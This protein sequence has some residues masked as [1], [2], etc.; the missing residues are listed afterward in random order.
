MATDNTQVQ[1][2]D[3]TATTIAQ[4]FNPEVVQLAENTAPAGG[5]GN[6]AAPQGPVIPGAPNG[7]VTVNVPAGQTVV[8]VQVA[9]GETIDLPFDGALA[10]K[11]GAQGNLAIK[12]GD[13]TIILLGYGAANQQTGVTLHDH[14]GHAIDVA[15]VVAQTDPN[16]DIQ[17]AA[18]PAAGPAG[19]GGHLFFGFTPN[20]GLGGLGELGVINPTELQYKLIQPDEQI[21]LVQ[22]QDTSPQLISITQGNAVNE[23]DFHHTYRG[24]GEPSVQAAYIDPNQDSSASPGLLDQINADSHFQNVYWG[25]TFDIND[26]GSGSG[27]DPFDTNDHEDGSQTPG[28]S[29]NAGGIDQD[30]E[31]L[32]STAKVTVN[33][34][35]DLPGEIT[36]DS[37]GQIPIIT[38]LQNQI[39]TSQGHELLYALLPATATHGESIVAYYET[40]PQG[41]TSQ[42]VVFSL[43][44]QQPLG[45][46][47]TS[48]FDVTFTIFGTLDNPFGA[49][50][51]ADNAGGIGNGV[52]N[53]DAVFFMRDSNGSVVESP[54]G[55]LVFHDYDDKPELGRFEYGQLEGVDIPNA[56]DPA[57]LTIGIDEH[58]GA[59]GEY[60]HTGT[61][62]DADL[63][64]LD[65]GGHLHQVTPQA[66]DDVPD[67]FFGNNASEIAHNLYG[68]PGWELHDAFAGTT[69]PASFALSLIDNSFF[70]SG[71]HNNPGAGLNVFTGAAETYL[72]VSFGADG[73]AIGNQTFDGKPGKAGAALFDGAPADLARGFELYMQNGDTHP[74][75]PD[76]TAANKPTDQQLT[77]LT[78]SYFDGEKV[79][80]LAVTAYQLDA[81]TIIGISAQPD[82]VGVVTER[83]A[84]QE[85]PGY[86]GGG[87]PVFALH[88]DPGSGLLT[89]VQYHQVDNLDI[90]HNPTDITHLLT[91]HD[92]QLV[93]FRATD[94]DGDHI[95]APLEITFT[96]T[97][98]EIVGVVYNNEDQSQDSGKLD[99]DFL[100]N[101]PSPNHDEDTSNAAPNGDGP[102]G[103]SV[104][105]HIDVTTGVDLPV[106]FSF[107]IA[108]LTKD[109][110][111]VAATDKDGNPLVAAGGYPI[112]LALSKSGNDWVVTGK[113][114]DAQGSHDA[115]TLNLDSQTG[116]FNFLLIQAL[117]HPDHGAGRFEDNLNL[118]FGV[119]VTDTDK[120]SSTA[121]L[122]FVVND[123]APMMIE[124]PVIT[125]TQTYGAEQQVAE[126]AAVAVETPCLQE[127]IFR[128]IV[129]AD[130]VPAGVTIS[131]TDDKGAAGTVNLLAGKGIGV[132]SDTDGG[133]GGRFDEINFDQHGGVS[134]NGGSEGLTFHFDHL[135]SSG[136]V[137]LAKFFSG[138]GGVGDERGHWSALLNGVEVGHGDFEANSKTGQFGFA[139]PVIAG[140]FDTLVFTALTGS[141]VTG[142]KGDQSDYLVQRL[143]LVA[144]P[145][146][147]QSGEFAFRFGADNGN[148]PKDGHA[149]DPTNT[150]GGE[151]FVISTAALAAKHLTSGG[152]ELQY[153]TTYVEDP[154]T[155]HT[156]V[157]ITG[158][159]GDPA[160]GHV[161]FVLDVDPTAGEGSG[162]EHGVHYT[163]TDY[164]P[165]DNNVIGM[166]N[167]PFDVTITDRDGDAIQTQI[168]VCIDDSKPGIDGDPVEADVYEKGLTHGSTPGDGSTVTS[169]FF[170]FFYNGDGPGHITNV[171]FQGF[172]G[173]PL[174]AASDAV[175]DGLGHLVIN[176]ALFNLA[177]DEITGAYTFTLKTKLDHLGASDLIQD[178][179]FDL[180]VQDGDGS[181][182]HQVNALIIHDHDDV[183]TAHD[184]QNS[185]FGSVD[186]LHAAGNVVTGGGE[187]VGGSDTPGADGAHVDS[188]TGVGPAVAVAAGAGGSII[189]G[190]YGDL[191]LHQD[192][193]YT[194]AQ[195]SPAPDNVQNEAFTYVLKDGDGDVSPATLSIAVSHAPQIELTTG[196]EPQQ[197]IAKTVNLSL[198]SNP[199]GNYSVGDYLLNTSIE[200]HAIDPALVNG[201]NPAN[202][203]M[204]FG[205][206][207]TVTFEREG[208]AYHSLVGVY[209]FDSLGNIIPGSVKFLWL[210]ATQVNEDVLHSALVNDPLGNAQPLNVDI[211]NF[212]AG[213]NLGFFLM[214]NGANDASVVAALKT[215]TGG[216]GHGYATDMAA[217]N[218]LTSIAVDGSGHG[219]VVVNGTQLPGDV[220]FTNKDLNTVGD[221]AEHALSGVSTPPDG[222]LYIGFEDKK[223]TKA[224][225][226]YND[227]V[228]GVNLGAQNL[229]QFTPAVFSP[230][231]N[232]GD[233]DNDIKQIDLVTTGFLVGD[234]LLNLASANG[235]IVDVTHTTNDYTVHITESVPNSHDATQWQNFVNSIGF[236]SNSQ[237]DGERD[238]TYTVTDV[239][240]N[241]AHTTAKIDVVTQ[242]VESLSVTALE[243]HGATPGADVTWGAGDDILHLDKNFTATDGKLDMGGGKNTVLLDANGENFTHDDAQHLLNV[244]HIDM[245][246]HNGPNGNATILSY[247]DVIGMTGGDHVL[248]IDGDAGIDK[249]NLT[250][251]G[252]ATGTWAQA[253]DVTIGGHTYN[254]YDWHGS[255][256]NTPADVLASVLVEHNLVQSVTD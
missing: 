114:S 136:T 250:G 166:S 189:H 150:H 199:D 230:N 40:G 123:D 244:Q 202:L 152:V 162:G 42:F 31:P 128:I 208:A 24:E 38:A 181:E 167:L 25:S 46:T 255:G 160:G 134:G 239:S 48:T 50:D 177:V 115:F 51:P 66:T 232:L 8:R 102:G 122:S 241:T 20:G 175:S 254:Q 70:N 80:H 17:T 131:A 184:D 137:E 228:F 129:T 216:G 193:S 65:P 197:V 251:N 212:P 37:N 125:H 195:H 90:N 68:Y 91:N 56:F 213:T 83:L 97:V 192:G 207:V 2:G 12:S 23:D 64:T 6:A 206:D 121:T 222:N 130:N 57:N 218:A 4:E 209:N 113:Y 235:F 243:H 11:F 22:Q 108:G 77:N 100:Y 231:L 29:D 183:P 94:F 170:N 39:L 96:D 78:I 141:A 245:T 221:G 234:S 13:Q 72:Q 155:H 118:D 229:Q 110:D 111:Q 233:Q 32:S 95:D 43:E 165:L 52:F 62:Y 203:H 214:V 149:G 174:I 21:L 159:K 163:F 60:N 146:N 55:A 225:K 63:N 82:Q 36:F 7:Q 179:K 120:D 99:E 217:L 178:L 54:S 200:G 154:A 67:S 45:T 132:V 33:F 71:D 194:Y 140:G 44:I 93:H 143:D 253:A 81:N 41:E 35:N 248:Q 171:H 198:P 252:G 85:L 58:P 92:S 14:K 157:V 186:H 190:L 112:T 249:V 98:P 187:P 164:L 75:T 191:T 226:D 196:D 76:G 49:L 19:Q 16:L 215:A 73:E 15:T 185:V 188:A 126:V 59:Q 105:G 79:E 107:H 172:A 116:D 151:G 89:L 246:G 173:T 133:A 138:E 84:A 142:A 104:S 117:Q 27:N 247:Q 153:A 144:Q 26:N 145:I 227:I 47:S 88:L 256:G 86:D 147:V 18:G 237:I 224:D 69:Q 211:G 148:L 1:Q 238:I 87:I 180:K 5:A 61:S 168:A 28:H 30:R 74:G 106:S 119:Q 127:N 109:G 210:D 242:H 124:Q 176:N 158:Y 240:H 3:D 101:L 169:G 139:L 219:H 34:F 205:A 220:L 201:V 223:I 135:I 9:P 53:L 161:A 156:H 236:S 10:A 204:S 182:A 103:K